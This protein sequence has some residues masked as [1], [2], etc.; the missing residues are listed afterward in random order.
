MGDA[1]VVTPRKQ[2]PASALERMRGRD[3]S[4]SRSER[5]HENES[6][7]SILYDPVG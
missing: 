7:E 3:F 4:S 6:A 2:P 1:G 5:G